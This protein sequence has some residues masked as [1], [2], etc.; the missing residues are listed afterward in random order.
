MIEV[1]SEEVPREQLKGIS[2]AEASASNH[3][4]QMDTTESSCPPQTDSGQLGSVSGWH[5]LF[6]SLFDSKCR[7]LLEH[8]WR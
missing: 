6:S 8:S 1:K 5:N 4:I 3:D 7:T 2:C